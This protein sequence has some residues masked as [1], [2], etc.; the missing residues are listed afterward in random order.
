[1]QVYK[2]ASNMFN[3]EPSVI[4]S[5]SLIFDCLQQFNDSILAKNIDLSFDVKNMG[6][7]I[8]SDKDLLYHALTRIFDCII[9]SSSEA[10]T[11]KIK[12]IDDIE[13]QKINIVIADES[14]LNI[15]NIAQANIAQIFNNNV[16]RSTGV[17]NLKIAENYLHL[18]G[19][20]I[21]VKSYD[22]LGNT[23]NIEIS[24][25]MVT[26]Q[27]QRDSNNFVV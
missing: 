12:L 24:G 7:F 19:C 18:L 3:I 5:E 9:R 13:N 26:N 11:L 15:T 22:G 2:I 14:S 1:M 23:L 27:H 8:I 10:S 16:I 6:L 4:S 17:L 20:K 25:D 21:T